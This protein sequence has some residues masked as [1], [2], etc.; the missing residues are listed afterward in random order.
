MKLLQ[1]KLLEISNS[2]NSIKEK[3][4]SELRELLDP[5]LNPNKE[6]TITCVSIR[7][8][9]QLKITISSCDAPREIEKFFNSLLKTRCQ[10]K[11]FDSSK[12]MEKNFKIIVTIELSERE[13]LIEG[14][15]LSQEVLNLPSAHRHLDGC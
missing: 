10:A 13:H 1:Q 3:E 15:K 5:R 7:E 9:M 14:L 12:W 8:D 4:D 11:K 6:H 2:I